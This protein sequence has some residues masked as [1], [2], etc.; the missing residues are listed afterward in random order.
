MLLNWYQQEHENTQMN[1]L[2]Q[3]ANY[4]DRKWCFATQYDGNT[5]A[6]Q[7]EYGNDLNMYDL[8]NIADLPDTHP[9]SKCELEACWWSWV[10]PHILQTVID[11][12]YNWFTIK[13]SN[14][15]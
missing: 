3:T 6:Y 4:Q 5:K 2:P 15:L 12:R 14:N 9:G 10:E 1:T 13:L 11:G 7:Y 8:Y